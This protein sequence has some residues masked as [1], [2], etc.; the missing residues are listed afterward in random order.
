MGSHAQRHVARVVP[1]ATEPL[2]LAEAKL[3][4]RVDGS[5]EDSLITDMITAVRE[6]A[7]AYMRASIISQTWAVTYDDYAPTCTPLPFGP[8]QLLS[9][10]I[11]ADRAGNETIID[12]G[13]YSLSA[14]N[15]AVQFD[16]VVMGHRVII[17][18]VAGYG[19][20]GDVP[21]AIRQGMLL[22]LAALYDNRLEAVSVPEASRTLYHTYRDVRLA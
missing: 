14:G 5:S 21:E 15:R 13:L 11:S 16:S 18:Y 6:S 8:V 7:E 1:P 20:A 12:D 9:S 19:D 17:R 3:F 22:H 4:L 2:S 10:V